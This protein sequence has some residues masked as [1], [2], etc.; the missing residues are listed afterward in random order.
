MLELTAE[1]KKAVDQMV[2]DRM[3]NTGE[4][5]EQASKH[6]AKYLERCAHEVADRK[7]KQ[8]TGSS[9]DTITIILSIVV[10]GLLLSIFGGFLYLV[11]FATS[12]F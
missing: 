6:I 11:R 1:Q 3:S 10:V 4:T 12:V 2:N 9:A 7:K 8:K 5:R